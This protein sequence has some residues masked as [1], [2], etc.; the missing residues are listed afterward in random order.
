M[1]KHYL[2][3]IVA[4]SFM[5]LPAMAQHSKVIT[6]WNYNNSKEYD[7]ARDAINL[8]I[9]NDETKGEAKTW[10]Y[11]GEAYQGL[12]ITNENKLR[13]AMDKSK[14]E[15]DKKA[16]DN[17]IVT[18]VDLKEAG[19]S[20]RKCIE[21]DEKNRFP[22]AKD[23]VHLVMITLQNFNDGYSAYNLNKYEVSIDKFNEFFLG[24]GAL[25]KNKS[26][27]DEAFANT[28]PPTDI[29]EAK[30]LMAGAEI[31][32]GHMDKAKSLLEGLANSNFNNTA[33][34]VNLSK[35]YL[36]AKDTAS[37]IASLDKGIAALPDDKKSGLL[38]EKLKILI[39]QG[40]Y[41]DAISVAE[42]AI[43]R[44]PKNIALYSALGKM[45]SEQKLYDQATAIYS[46]ALAVDPKD[47]TIAC[48]LGI[49]KFNQGVDKYNLSINSKSSTDADKFLAEAKDIWK[50]AAKTLEDATTLPKKD[51]DRDDWR[52]CYD[53]L[54]QI[55]YKLNDPVNGKKYKELYKQN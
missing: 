34:Y 11:R 41:K 9:L 28:K 49:V 33:V 22:E 3:S 14:S 55:Y 17:Y 52:A 19:V 48:G 26:K 45:Y 36:E 44:E 27:I 35:F 1:K 30:L 6:A 39:K 50:G 40:K 18:N 37:A 43:A 23:Q 38:I 10:L 24:Y 32:L 21:L 47:F 31:Q 5:S 42:A 7:K 2:F 51:E 20:Y 8:A 13:D 15:A 53:A 4:A 12:Y 46:K 54:S 29:R 16:Y 25:G